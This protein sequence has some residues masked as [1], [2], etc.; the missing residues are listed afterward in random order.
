M[1]EENLERLQSQLNVIKRITGV[2]YPHERIDVRIGYAAGI[3]CLLP[4]FAGILSA[5]SRSL[6]LASSVPF[7]LTI[8]VG[9]A[10]NYVRCHPRNECPTQKRQYHR[11]GTPVM[12]VVA[13]VLFGVQRWE[14]SMGTPAGVANGTVMVFLGLLLLTGGLSDRFERHNI[15]MGIFAIVGGL[16]WPVCEFQQLW[17]VLWALTAAGALTGTALLHWQMVHSI[18]QSRLQNGTN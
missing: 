14:V 13:F 17:V 8:I 6:L 7:L 12:L 5:E 4:L 9:V 1:D 11:V 2:E 16:L 15:P 10:L 18:D 3:A